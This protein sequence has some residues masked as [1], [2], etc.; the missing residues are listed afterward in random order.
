MQ[1]ENGLLSCKFIITSIYLVYINTNCT[2]RIQ[3]IVMKSYFLQTPHGPKTTHILKT[4]VQSL[5]LSIIGEG[6]YCVQDVLK[7]EVCIC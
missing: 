3:N 6:V 4:A 2:D 7:I 5:H 1:L